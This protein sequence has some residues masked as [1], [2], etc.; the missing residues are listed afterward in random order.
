M[1]VKGK[2]SF[3][4]ILLWSFL[5]AIIGKVIVA[6]F[7]P[8]GGSTAKLVYEIE[9][10]VPYTVVHGLEHLT[11]RADPAGIPRARQLLKSTHNEIWLNAALYLGVCKQQEA[12]PY[13]IKALR[14]TDSY[15]D[16]KTVLYLK[17][18][19]G[20]EFGTD[21]SKWQQWWLSDHPG[22]VFDWES[23]LG[24][25]PRIPNDKLKQ[26]TPSVSSSAN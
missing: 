23:C 6:Y 19:T 24:S 2:T 10:L 9:S 3:G 11:E 20:E 13:L 5:G 1:K 21:F 18:I 14:H 7:Y 16:K 17:N 12:A 4:H 8:E 25:R 22:F 15:V 26:K